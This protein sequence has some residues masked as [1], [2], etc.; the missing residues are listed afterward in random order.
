MYVGHSLWKRINK[1]YYVDKEVVVGEKRMRTPENDAKL[2][3]KK[4]S[5]RS[6]SSFVHWHTVTLTIMW[7]CVTDLLLF[8]SRVVI[9]FEAIW[10]QKSS[11]VRSTQPS[12]PETANPERSGSNIEMMPKYPQRRHETVIAFFNTLSWQMPDGYGCMTS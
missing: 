12:G 10:N 6:L 1:N 3:K 7:S 2:K 9:F 11:E 8:W 5:W 4:L